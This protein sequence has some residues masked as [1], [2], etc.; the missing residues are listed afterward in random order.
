MLLRIRW[1][2]SSR[3]F[4]LANFVSYNVGFES[5]YLVFK[6]LFLKLNE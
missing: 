3:H 6:R 1:G 2:P 4:D 5:K